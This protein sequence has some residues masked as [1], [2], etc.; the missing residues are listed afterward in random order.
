MPYRLVNVAANQSSPS[1]A[2][3][4]LGTPFAVLLATALLWVFDHRQ[5]VFPAKLIGNCLHFV[6]VLAGA[7]V[8]DAVRK[9]YGVDDKVVVQMI[10]FVKVGGNDHLIAVAPKPGRQLYANLMRQL[11]RGLAGGK[12]LIAVV[13]HR[14]ILLAKPLFHCKHFITGGS[15]RAVNARHK[16]VK[17]CAVLAARF[18]RFL[19]I[20]GVADH[21]GKLLPV[22]FGQFPIGVEFRVRRLFGVLRIDH[23]LAEP[24]FY[25]PNRS[26]CHRRITSSNG[27]E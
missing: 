9:G 8:F 14:A 19:R 4:L 22:L 20:D 11:R 27:A 10:F 21:I 2:L 6:V 16:T 3:L 23:H 13:G 15:G 1:G 25:P 17:R 24:A 5:P 12:G 18:L 7:V 26:C